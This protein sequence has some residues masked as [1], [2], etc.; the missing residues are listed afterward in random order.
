[1]KKKSM[2]RR[3]FLN[4]S[5]CIGA[6]LAASRLIRGATKPESQTKVVVVE[7]W[8]SLSAGK[9]VQKVVDNMVSELVMTATGKSNVDQAWRSIVSGSKERVV[10]KFNALF[11][12]ATTSPEVIVSV[13]KGLV[14]A[15]VSEERISIFDNKPEDY[16]NIGFTRV[17]GFSRIKC[18]NAKED[19]GFGRDVVAGKV[20]TQLAKI[21]T[22]DTDVLINL[23]RLKHHCLAGFTAS[24]K[25]HLGSIPRSGARAFHDALECIADL[26]ALEPIT[27]KTR[28]SLVDGLIGIYNKGPMYQPGC[29]W[30][31]YRLIG[32]SDPVAVDAVALDILKKYRSTL[33]RS[34]RKLTPEVVYLE[35]AEKIGLGV[36]DTARIDCHVHSL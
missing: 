22:E 12:Q 17:P 30:N 4:K 16:K 28:F 1:M 6:G 18:L 19:G 10:I 15:G 23:S 32:G 7:D 34:L 35:R 20:T 2:S 33:K 24:L 9:P 31:A 13:I 5:A 21:I 3:I 29:T 27:L 36:A 11:R 14:H 26:N 8:K 25:N